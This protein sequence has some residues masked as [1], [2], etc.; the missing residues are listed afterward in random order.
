[1]DS[2]L[3]FMRKL[4]EIHSYFHPSRFAVMMLTPMFFN[5]VNN[6]SKRW[7][8]NVYTIKAIMATH[9]P[10]AVA[11]RASSTPVMA[12]APVLASRVLKEPII[13]VAGAQVGP[14]MGKCNGCT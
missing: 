6:E 14:T 13:P 5:L 7:L 2:G 12:D 4:Y 11:I 1:M 8:K 9:R 10:V 3:D